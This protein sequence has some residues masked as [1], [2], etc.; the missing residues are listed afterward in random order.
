MEKYLISTNVDGHVC[1][2]YSTEKLMTKQEALKKLA[3][4]SEV[5]PNARLVKVVEIYERRKQFGDN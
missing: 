4:V 2:N 1:G 3:Y 5:D